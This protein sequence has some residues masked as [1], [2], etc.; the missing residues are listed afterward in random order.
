[1]AHALGERVVVEKRRVFYRYGQTRIH[2]DYVAALGAFVELET[3]MDE[4][5]ETVAV[6][7][8]QR[9]IDLLGLDTLPIV[10]S[11]YSDLLES[12]DTAAPGLF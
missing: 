3:L 1:L 2:F 6:A 5:T 9:V 8:H 10:A 4:A 11:S 7:E 12:K